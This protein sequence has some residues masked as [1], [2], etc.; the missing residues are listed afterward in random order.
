MV[1]VVCVAWVAYLRCVGVFV[2]CVC[3]FVCVCECGMC[4]VLVSAWCFIC[5]M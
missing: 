4:G 5:G 3:K 1:R 2:W